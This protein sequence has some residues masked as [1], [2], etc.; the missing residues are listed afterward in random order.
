[1]KAAQTPKQ[2]DRAKLYEQ[3]QVIVKEEAPW[4]T[5]AHSVRFDPMRKEVTGLQDGCDGASLLQQRRSGETACVS[6]LRPRRRPDDA[7]GAPDAVARGATL[8]A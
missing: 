3:A 6:V 8:A 1:M 5:I 2:A 4:I 7:S